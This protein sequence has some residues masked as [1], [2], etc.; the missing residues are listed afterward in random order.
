MA[1]KNDNL[2]YERETLS[3]YDLE[4]PVEDVIE[5]LQAHQAPGRTQVYLNVEWYYDEEGPQDRC[6]EVWVSWY[7]EKTPAEIEADKKAEKREKDLAE[8]RRLADEYG[9]ELP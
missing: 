2:V 4:G 7:R 5:M 8:L 1:R 6:R 3:T 9:I